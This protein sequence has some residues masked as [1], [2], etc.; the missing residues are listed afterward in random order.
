M[1]LLA[2]ENGLKALDTKINDYELDQLIENMALL[3]EKQNDNK[4]YQLINQLETQINDVKQKLNKKEKESNEPKQRNKYEP[5]L[6]NRINNQENMI[7]KLQTR[8]N[9]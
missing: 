6:I 1:K 5:E 9:N 4:L 2:I 3:L 7:T 8:F